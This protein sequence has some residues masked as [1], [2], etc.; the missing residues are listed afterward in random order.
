MISGKIAI[1]SICAGFLTPVFS[2][3]IDIF[4]ET[5]ITKR[6]TLNFREIIKRCLLSGCVAGWL[7]GVVYYAF[8]L[9]EATPIR[10]IITYSIFLGIVAPI[11]SKSLVITYSKLLSQRKSSS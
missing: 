7:L 8:A 10:M 3:A 1:A 4:F 6:D 9:A 5:V 11:L 2:S